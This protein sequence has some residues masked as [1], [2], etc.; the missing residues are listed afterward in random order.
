M[1][2]SALAL[3][4]LCSQLRATDVSGHDSSHS[5]L[6]L[7][8]TKSTLRLPLSLQWLRRVDGVISSAS[9]ISYTD[10]QKQV[11]RLGVGPEDLQRSIPASKILWSSGQVPI[12]KIRA[13]KI[14]AAPQ[15]TQ[16]S[17]KSSLSQHFKWKQDGHE[18]YYPPSD[19]WEWYYPIIYSSGWKNANFDKRVCAA[20]H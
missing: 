20:A 18:G 13:A 4:S 19:N 16:T 2:T 14:R 17:Y 7:G 6:V 12:I 5:N 10:A 15:V 1:Q 3:V 8:Q 11:R 9:N